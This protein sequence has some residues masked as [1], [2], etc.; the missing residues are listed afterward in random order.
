MELIAAD[1]DLLVKLIYIWNNIIG[2]ITINSEATKN[3]KAIKCDIVNTAERISNVRKYLNLVHAFGECNTT[4][5]AMN[6]INCRY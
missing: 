1:T 4:S 5:A 3:Y 2:G 6:K